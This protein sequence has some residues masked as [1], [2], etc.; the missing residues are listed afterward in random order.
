MKITAEILAAGTGSSA[1]VAKEW[2]PHIQ[3]AM[4]AN[5][6]KTPKS[7]GCFLANIGVESGGLTAVVENLNYSADAL[8]RVWPARYALPKPQVGPKG[9]RIP[10]ATA[11]RIARRPEVIAN[12]TYADRMGNGNPESGDGWRYRGRGLIQVT[13]KAMYAEVSGEIGHDFV[14]K[15]EDMEDKKWAA[16]S[17]AVYFKSHGCIEAAEQTMY[18]KVVE[19]INGA[20]PSDAN[21]GPL[22]LERT[23]L[24]VKLLQ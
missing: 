23:R 20:K 15:P 12:L 10:N 16:L 8:A 9:E 2:L 6:I 17:A 1:S 14:A 19:I 3:S 22:R 13:G 7:I 11:T 4:D 5:G 18:S 21:H 24:V